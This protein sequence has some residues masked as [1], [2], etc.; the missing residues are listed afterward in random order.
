[1][2]S[3]T[4]KILFIQNSVDQKFRLVL[5]TEWSAKNPNYRQ[6]I[7]HCLA[8]KL[9]SHFS[10]VQLAQL[11][12]LNRRPEASDRFISISHCKLLGGFALSQFR[13]GFDVE[14]TQRI[15]Q[16]ILKRV[17]DES[18][19]Q[20]CPQLEFLWVAKEAG[21]KALSQEQPT[22]MISN[23]V[24]SDFVCFDWASHYENQVFSFRLKAEKTLEFG[25]NKGF[26]FSNDSCLFALFFK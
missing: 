18:E 23:L 10:R 3:L 6:N 5:D 11:Y 2:A 24:I 19:L 20:D 15:S 25:L 9:S 14:E 12:D 1:M 17:C 13:V 26:I 7:R 4:D 8:T 22:L 21:F 16:A